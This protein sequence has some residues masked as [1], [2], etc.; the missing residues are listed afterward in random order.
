MCATEIS[1]MVNN[2]KHD[3]ALNDDIIKEAFDDEEHHIDNKQDDT[4][5]VPVPVRINFW[6]SGTPRYLEWFRQDVEDGKTTRV[7]FTH[8]PERFG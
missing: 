3:Y 5:C 1:S 8:L 4:P 7:I 6:V 2:R